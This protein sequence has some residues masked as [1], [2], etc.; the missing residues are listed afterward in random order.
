MKRKSIWSICVILLVS[1][2]Y[3][4][5]FYSQVSGIELLE[6]VERENISEI[7][8]R[9]TL[10]DGSG[11]WEAGVCTLSPEEIEQF[12]AYLENSQLKD[13][14]IQAVP[15][16]SNI[17]YYVTL[18]RGGGRLAGQL[19][20]YDDDILIFD[21]TYGNRPGVHKRYIIISSSISSFFEAV[22]K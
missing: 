11:C 1:G 12:Y 9:K 16:E 10:E 14:G 22:L 5:F 21:Y 15:I 7:L 4:L 18:N 17:R 13:I 8:I 3:L 20:F 2:I 6:Y 19:E